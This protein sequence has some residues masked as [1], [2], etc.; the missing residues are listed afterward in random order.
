MS[1]LQ[2]VGNHALLCS[3]KQRNYSR[4]RGVGRCS[5][6]PCW[7]SPRIISKLKLTR[8][9]NWSTFCASTFISRSR[10]T[11]NSP[12]VLKACGTEW[13]TDRSKAS[14]TPPPRYVIK[15]LIQWILT[16]I[17]LVQLHGHWWK[18]DRS[19]CAD[20]QR[21]HLEAIKPRCVQQLL[22]DEVVPRGWSARWCH[23]LLAWR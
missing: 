21:R 19:S 6:P 2:W 3:W 8:R 11:N 7:A 22:R 4:V 12:R 14:S 16:Y 1:G 20:G 10:Y 18:F 5:L 23:Q 17:A 13:C 15:S 9:V